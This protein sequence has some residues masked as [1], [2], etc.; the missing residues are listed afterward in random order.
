M[1]PEQKSFWRILKADPVWF[2]HDCVHELLKVNNN[3]TALNQKAD[4]LIG[5]MLASLSIEDMA[6]VLK[7]WL[8]T[9]KLALDANKLNNFD[10]FHIRVGP[11]I[12]DNL[13]SISA[14]KKE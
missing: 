7:T 6:A 8:S 12:M 4:I 10:Q 14:I 5:Q 11:W 13:H 1:T 9:Y 3:E 2:A